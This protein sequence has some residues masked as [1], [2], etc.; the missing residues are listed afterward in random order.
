MKKHY[1]IIFLLILF[2]LFTLPIQGFAVA[3]GHSGGSTGNGRSSGGSFSRGHMFNDYSNSYHR[4]WRSQRYGNYG[5][6]NLE[7]ELFMGISLGG[8]VFFSIFRRKKGQGTKINELYDYMP[9]TKSEKKK[10]IS[11][12]QRIFFAIQ[13]AW[14]E[15]KLEKAKS[16]YSDKLLMEHQQILHQNKNTGVRNHTKKIILQKLGNYRQIREDS[17]SIRIDFSCYDYV[18]DRVNKQIVSGY[19]HKRQHFS[20]VWYFNYSEKEEKWQADFIQPLSLE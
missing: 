9:G 7:D 3:G 6:Y 14:E 16:Y 1:V 10:K 2:F 8:M 13:T 15:E 20:Q 18:V 5:S 12:I 19:K 11:E 4:G 17:F